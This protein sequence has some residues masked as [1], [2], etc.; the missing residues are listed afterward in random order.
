MWPGHALAALGYRAEI[1]RRCKGIFSSILIAL[2]G[3]IAGALLV[4]VVSNHAF[5]MLIPFLLLVATLLFAFGAS[6]SSWLSSNAELSQS[7][8]FSRCLEFAIA[9]YGGFFGAGLGVMLMVGL[10]VLGVR[11][12]QT[13]NALK[14]LLGAVANSA[15]VVVF[16]F[17]GIVSWPHT[18]IVFA[19]ASIGG[20]LGARFARRLAEVWLR[21]IVIATGCALTVHYFRIYYG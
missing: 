3:G 2:A 11:D 5:S 4:T 1:A 13:N 12:M 20:L 15:A 9:V 8:L 16:A 14:N 18:L 6:L 7:N 17:S 21:R 10:L 19:G